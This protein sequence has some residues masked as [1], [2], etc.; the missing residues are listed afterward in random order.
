MLRTFGVA[1]V[2]VSTV[3]AAG[4]QTAQTPPPP[5]N[6]AE[7]YA[8]FLIGHHLDETDDEAGAIAAYTRAMELDPA[9]ADI[10]AELA[11]LYLR[12]NY[13]QAATTSDVAHPA[14]QLTSTRPSLPVVTLTLAVLSR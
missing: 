6:V 13:P 9:A 4:A 1:L 5:R 7:A 10:P 8:Q 3:M 14:L 11:A 2:L 12:Q